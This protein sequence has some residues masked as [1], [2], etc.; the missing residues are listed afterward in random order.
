M[1][2]TERS[3]LLTAFYWFRFIHGVKVTTINGPVMLVSR[4]WN[5][6]DQ[7]SPFHAK[8][9]L[10]LGYAQRKLC[11]PDSYRDSIVARLLTT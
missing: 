10:K 4:I 3:K 5:D 7:G 2:A 8:A 11:N 6:F 1:F 9:S